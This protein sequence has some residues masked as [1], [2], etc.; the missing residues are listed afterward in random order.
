LR[1]GKFIYYIST[2][3]IFIILELAALTMLY[4]NGPL[5]RTWFGN[6]GQGF[7]G[8]VWGF[9]QQIND[10]FSLK[11]INDSLAN[12]NAR[13]TILLA[14]KADSL[15]R[16]SLAEMLPADNAAGSFRYTP[17]VIRKISNNTQHNYMMLDKGSSDGVKEGNGVITAKGA[18]G[19]IEAVSENYSYALSFK[20][21]QMSI[22]ARLRKDGP[23]G[24]MNWDGKSQNKA[25][26]KEI[27][28]HIDL[29]DG[30][31]VYT[32]GYS[33]MFPA[34]IPLGTTGASKIVNGATY[35][36]EISLFEDMSSLRYAII[37]DNLD[38]DEIETLEAQ[39]Q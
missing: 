14:G 24:T 7:S 8:W 28:H 20:N 18:V 32:S 13:L 27:P 37:V 31:T 23:V 21:H 16:E 34:D 5:Q 36:I 15:T 25:L 29:A 6:A 4:N 19:I 3:A 9:T 30:D 1:K 33:S 38:D 35:E 17:A 26:L 22:S 10:Y 11:E 39:K 2:A 12:D